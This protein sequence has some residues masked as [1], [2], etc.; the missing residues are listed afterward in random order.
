MGA[1]RNRD[2]QHRS[3]LPATEKV[4]GCA[5]ARTRGSHVESSPCPVG[6]R[7]GD[8]RIEQLRRHAA[9]H[10]EPD[11]EQPDAGFVAGD[12]CRLQHRGTGR[13]W[14]ERAVVPHPLGQPAAELR[15][16]RQRAGDQPRRRDGTAIR[17][18]ELRRRPEHQPL[19]ARVVGRRGERLAGADPAALAVHGQLHHA[20][21]LLVGQH[22]GAFLL[23]RHRARLR[24]R[25]QS[26]GRH[27]RSGCRHRPAADL[28]PWRRRHAHPGCQLRRRRGQRV[29]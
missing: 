4:R 8:G 14:P 29:R 20:V 22:R 11:V 15:E 1:A 25:R 19:R 3:V 24:L 27:R 10:P 12:R 9:D 7:S 2:L 6:G 21:H 16:P 18:R 23:A 26:R 17:R 13:R 5:P 28:A